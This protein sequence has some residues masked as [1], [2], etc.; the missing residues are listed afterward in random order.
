MARK[1]TEGKKKKLQGITIQNSSGRGIKK[2]IVIIEILT[3]FHQNVSHSICHFSQHI[4]LAFPIPVN[5]SFVCSNLC[6]STSF[7]LH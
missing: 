2:D 6:I 7:E 3:Q 5:K 1:Q 4:Y